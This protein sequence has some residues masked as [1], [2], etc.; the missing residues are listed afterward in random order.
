MLGYVDNDEDGTDMAFII[1]LLARGVKK[2]E[3]SMT[4]SPHPQN[5]PS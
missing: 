5:L 2:G 4:V 1:K 3:A